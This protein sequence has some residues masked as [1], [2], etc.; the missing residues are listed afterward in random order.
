MPE[1]PDTHDCQQICLAIGCGDMSTGEPRPVDPTLV[2][3]LFQRLCG[4]ALQLTDPVARFAALE[5]GAVTETIAA[6]QRRVAEERGTILDE[7]YAATPDNAAVGRAVGV[8]RQR[9]GQLRAAGEMAR[10]QRLA[11]TRAI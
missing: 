6:L 10:A 3:D 8:S 11:A 5:A 7:L 1:T 2:D 9:V 4:S